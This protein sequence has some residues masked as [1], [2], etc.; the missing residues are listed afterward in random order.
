MKFTQGLPG[1]LPPGTDY[2]YYLEDEFS[3]E[4]VD[5]LKDLKAIPEDYT[6][7]KYKR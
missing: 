1:H 5:R 3:K 4:E 6:S 7:E 2:L